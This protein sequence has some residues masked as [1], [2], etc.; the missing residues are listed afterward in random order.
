MCSDHYT[1]GPPAS[2]NDRSRVRSRGKKSQLERKSVES[3]SVDLEKEGMTT[4]TSS[5]SPTLDLSHYRMV[6]GMFIFGPNFLLFQTILRVPREFPEEKALGAPTSCLVA[7][8][9]ISIG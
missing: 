9:S 6:D 5:H 3:Q 2:A 1:S 4:S 8:V 7:Q